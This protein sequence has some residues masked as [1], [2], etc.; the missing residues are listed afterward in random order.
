MKAAS[1]GVYVME[2]IFKWTPVAL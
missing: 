2:G 1:D